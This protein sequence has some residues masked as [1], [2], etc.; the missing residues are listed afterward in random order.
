MQT[1]ILSMDEIT[2]ICAEKYDSMYVDVIDTELTSLFIYP[3]LVNRVCYACIIV[4]V[5]RKLTQMENI[6]V[7]RGAS[8]LALEL[9]KRQ[10]LTEFHN[11]KIHDFYS[12]L[13]K[14]RTPTS[15]I[16]RGWSMELI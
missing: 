14:M 4:I 12:D 13:L 11:K 2:K 7:E 1:T 8:V 6:I 5:P 3:I 9:A 10:L 16:N 15:F